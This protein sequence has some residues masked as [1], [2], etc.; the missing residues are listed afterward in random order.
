MALAGKTPQ[1][2]S[3][4]WAT[5]LGQAAANQGPGGVLAGAQAYVNNG[6]NPMAAAAADP[7]KWVQGV[8]AAATKWRTRL[9]QPNMTGQYWLQSLQT[10]GLNRIGTGA[11]AASAPNGKFTEF[12]ADLL[13]FEQTQ[14]AALNASNPRGDLNA[15]ITRA[16][17]WM[18]K[19][20][21]FRQS[22]PMF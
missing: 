21:G 19:M 5:N 20:S 4:K 1:G 7:Q 22:N 12:M 11:Q 3:T 9:T 13:T 6:G 18:Q 17:V 10:K 15:N 2:V 8:T 14:L 16:T